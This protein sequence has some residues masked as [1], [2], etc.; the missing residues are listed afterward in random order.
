V[1]LTVVEQVGYLA[2]EP[3]I[4]GPGR[5]LGKSPGSLVKNLSLN[6]ITSLTALFSVSGLSSFFTSTE[7]ECKEPIV[8]QTPNQIIYYI[9]LYHDI[10]CDISQEVT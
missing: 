8:G 6:G 3:H 2:L 1:I 4:P 9:I 7:I 10:S 5:R